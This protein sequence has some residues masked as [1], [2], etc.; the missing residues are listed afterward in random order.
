[1]NPNLKVVSKKVSQDLFNQKFE[2]YTSHFVKFLNIG[3]GIL[4]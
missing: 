2:E 3:V 4:P 1:M